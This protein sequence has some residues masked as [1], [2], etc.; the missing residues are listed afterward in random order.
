MEIEK[1][2]LVEALPEQLNQYRKSEIEQIY[3]S[4]E[5]VIRLRKTDTERTLTIKGS[6]LLSR[7]EYELAITHEQYEKLAAKIE[8]GTSAI[9]KTRYYIPLDGALTAELDVYQ[10]F[11][12]G[13]LIVE[14]EFDTVDAAKNFTP[15]KWFGVDVTEKSEYKNAVLT[16]YVMPI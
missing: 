3:I 7:E 14:V 13:L 15:P 11:L 12:S 4:T 1:K 5:P 16:N 10:G 8:K 6:G 2:Y 9:E